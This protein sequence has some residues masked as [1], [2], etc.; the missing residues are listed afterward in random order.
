MVNTHNVYSQMGLE[1]HMRYW[2]SNQL[3]NSIDIFEFVGSYSQ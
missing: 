1:N 3:K 2:Q